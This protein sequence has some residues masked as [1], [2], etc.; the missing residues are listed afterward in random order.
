MTKFVEF[1]GFTGIG[2]KERLG[3]IVWE[4]GKKFTE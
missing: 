4:K 2:V 1:S 3:K